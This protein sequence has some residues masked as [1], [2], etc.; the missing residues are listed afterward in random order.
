M[1]ENPIPALRADLA[2]RKGAWPRIARDSD[3]SY[4]WLCKFAGGFIPNPG[5][6]TLQRL[7][8]ALHTNTAGT[9]PQPTEA[10]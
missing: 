4:S 10:A 9:P 1:V 7:H 8:D 5:I 3:V 2:A 6:G